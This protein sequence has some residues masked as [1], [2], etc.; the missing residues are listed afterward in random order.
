MPM[1]A[2]DDTCVRMRHCL[3]ELVDD[4][5]RHQRRVVG[6]ASGREDDR[7]LGALIAP[8]CRLAH[9]GEQPR[10]AWF[11]SAARRRRRGPGY[12]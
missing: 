11:P 3:A 6:R 12:R 9:R 1:L 5:L 8:R 2:G 7:E 4:L 10:I